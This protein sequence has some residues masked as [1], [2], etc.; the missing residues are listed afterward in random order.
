MEAKKARD[1]HSCRSLIGLL[2]LDIAQAGGEG[3]RELTRRFSH[4]EVAMSLEFP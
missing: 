4:S 1:G 2:A 3:M